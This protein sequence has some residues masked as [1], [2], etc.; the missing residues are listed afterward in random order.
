MLFLSTNGCKEYRLEG[1]LIGHKNAINCL[2][3]SRNGN[4]LASGGKW[5][6]QND[7]YTLT[8]VQAQTA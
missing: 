1:R 3:V 5:N 8:R 6:I 7:I 2:A 4:M